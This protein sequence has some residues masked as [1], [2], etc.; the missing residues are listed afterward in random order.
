MN[1]HVKLNIALRCF[2]S[3]L[4]KAFGPDLKGGFSVIVL[5]ALFFDAL[6]RVGFIYIIDESFT[7]FRIFWRWVIIHMINIATRGIS[8]AV[9]RPSN[10]FISWCLK[11]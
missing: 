2:R 11:E 5:V 3:I 1:W 10:A 8:F 4:T 7:E 6:L 9:L